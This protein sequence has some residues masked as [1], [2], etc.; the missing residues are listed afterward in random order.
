MCRETP[1][2]KSTPR[3][4]SCISRTTSSSCRLSSLGRF[5]ISM[6]I[7]VI[8]SWLV[9]SSICI[10]SNRACLREMS[11]R[12]TAESIASCSTFLQL[13]G[14]F[15]TSAAVGHSLT[16]V[17]MRSMSALGA[18]TSSPSPNAS[19]CG[20]QS[21]P[22]FDRPRR[23]ADA[24][25]PPRKSAAALQLARACSLRTSSASTAASCSL[26]TCCISR[27]NASARSIAPLPSTP[28]AVARDDNAVV[29][30]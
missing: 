14:L 17:S 6:R 19:P 26:S 15:G 25:S 20:D 28:S 2:Q 12:L 9:A 13:R 30:K 5:W 3:G 8:F 1:S 29:L 16:S 23:L 4:S 18:G 24:P 10:R 21:R 7:S 11:S 27:F 22:A